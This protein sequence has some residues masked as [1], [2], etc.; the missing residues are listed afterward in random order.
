MIAR[1]NSSLTEIE[2]NFIKLSPEELDGTS[3]QHDP[4]LFI[5]KVRTISLVS[6]ENNAVT[7]GPGGKS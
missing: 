3:P 2:M 7:S 1:Y 6:N 5:E 4:S